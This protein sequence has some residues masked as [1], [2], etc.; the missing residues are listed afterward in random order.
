MG[1]FDF[2]GDS[3]VGGAIGGTLNDVG[4][5]YGD[6]FSGGAV[7][8]AKEQAAANER[9]VA[10][11]REQMGFQE[12]MSNS[13]Y[14]RAVADM[15]AAGLNPALAYQN[16]GASQPT[17]SLAQVSP[18][19]KGKVAGGVMNSAMSLYGL[20]QETKKNNSQ[21]EL[22][23]SQAENNRAQIG[24]TEQN[25]EK[26]TANAQESRI[27]TELAKKQIE[28][29]KADTKAARARAK[30]EENDAK[31]SDSRTGIDQKMAPADAIMDRVEQGLGS[32]G[33]GLRNL[34]RGGNKQRSRRGP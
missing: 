23:T 8:S 18:E 16:G 12:R 32:I 10:L 21:I 26:A 14:Q 27:N 4:N 2:M 33:T 25:A 29:V 13:A 6:M 3:G 7:T 22:N 30:I 19:G 24:L 20:G 5:I 17:G 1:L 15:K 11:M 28:K 34:F 31:V 9:N